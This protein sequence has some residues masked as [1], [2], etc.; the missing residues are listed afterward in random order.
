[1]RTSTENKE[2][3]QRIRTQMNQAAYSFLITE[4]DLAR[5]FVSLAQTTRY[6]E[7]RRRT[8]NLALQA[9]ATVIKFRSRLEFTEMQNNQLDRQLWTVRKLLD[10]AQAA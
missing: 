1:M 2:E 3:A 8:L 6:P 4:L 10:E 7:K 9:C 5:A